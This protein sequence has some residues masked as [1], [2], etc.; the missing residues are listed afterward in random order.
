MVRR[1]LAPK[2]FEIFKDGKLIDQNAKSKDY[3][4]MLEQTVLGFSYAAFKQVVI[5]GK[6]SF[7]PFMQLTPA[8]RR[9]IIEGLLDLDIIASMG[10]VVK[11]KLSEL[12][13]DLQEH[14]SMLKIAREK[15]K[16]QNELLKEIKQNFSDILEKNEQKREELRLNKTELDSKIAENQKLVKANT[17]L[18]EEQLDKIYKLKEIAKIENKMKMQYESLMEDITKTEQQTSCTCCEQE[19]SKEAKC[20]ILDAKYSKRD[21]YTEALKEI[22][23]KLQNLTDMEAKREELQ[24]VLKEANV[25]Q[26][27]MKKENQILQSRIFEIEE[28]INSLKSKHLDNNEIYDKIRSTES[29]IIDKTEIYEKTVKEQIH[30]DVVYDMLRDSG[31]KS[32]II[33]HYV[34]IINN[35]V[36][37]Y[38][39]KLNLYVDFHL[40]EEFKETIKSRYRDEF[41]YSSFSEGEKQRIDLAILLTWREIAKMKNSLNCNLLIFDEILDS[42]LDATGTET[43]LKMLAK[44][45]NKCSVFIIS[46]KSDQLIDKFDQGIQVEKKN[47]FS[48]IKSV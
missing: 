43:F 37:K 24:S 38:L 15:L 30:Y 17:K 32:K 39:D 35:Y 3:Q 13:T 34:P 11:C 2:I 29:D 23:A 21:E 26:N 10:T 40:N 9:K 47:N 46:H 16:S 33:K 42:S 12:K 14:E 8:E 25:D 20:K 18:L 36:N 4:E 31:L 22:S 45:K 48:R 44:L 7:I 5:L 27:V 6:S 41:S 19:L 28:E 1:G